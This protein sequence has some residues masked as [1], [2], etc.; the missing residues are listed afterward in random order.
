M[1]PD[2]QGA[3]GAGVNSDED[4]W[5]WLVTFSDLVLQLFGFAVIAALAGGVAARSAG[6]AP[7]AVSAPPAQVAVGATAR[8]HATPA[9][10][11][12]A[13]AAAPSRAYDLLPLPAAVQSDP[14]ADPDAV[15]VA[16]PQ[17]A[18]ALAAASKPAPSITRPRPARADAMASLAGYLEQLVALQPGLGATV[19]A[20]NDGVVVKIGELA[21]FG[22][23]SAD[24]APA[25]RPLLDELRALV[26]AAT[27]LHVEVS[28][29]TDDVPIS[30]ASFPSNLEL[31]LARASRVAN[32]LA[33]S[34]A[35][36]RARV[37]AAGYAEQRPIASNAAPEGRARNRRVEI[38]LT[39]PADP[40]RSG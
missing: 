40:G 6:V 17:P 23:G 9:V 27:D 11:Q 38:R 10:A 13:L 15:P 25:M 3:S 2:P 21:G 14:D 31:S 29:H 34:D 19:S 30:T 32:A 20:Q 22:P 5:S 4:S 1:L 39:R 35:T 24:P 37:S 8:E 36:L 12:P 33:G 26:A 18:P 16:A 28:G 7:A